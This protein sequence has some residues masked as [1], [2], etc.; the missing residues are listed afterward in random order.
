MEVGSSTPL[1]SLHLHDSASAPYVYKNSPTEQVTWWFQSS[2][3]IQKNRETS[4]P[5]RESKSTAPS[6]HNTDYAIP[7]TISST[8]T[9]DTLTAHKLFLLFYRWINRRVKE[10]AGCQCTGSQRLHDTSLSVHEG[11]GS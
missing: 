1:H 6:S 3:D 5:S 10:N 7:P 8:G 9:S 11:E 2:T 4:S